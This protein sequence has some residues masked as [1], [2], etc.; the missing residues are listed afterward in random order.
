MIIYYDSSEQSWYHTRANEQFTFGADSEPLL[1][2]KTPTKNAIPFEVICRNNGNLGPLVG[3]L[4]SRNKNALITGNKPLFKLLQGELLDNGGISVVMTLEDLQ[5]NE[6]NGYVYLPYQKKWLKI[7]IPFPHIVYNRIPIRKIESSEI[8]RNTV[9]TFQEKGVKFFNPSFLNKYYLYELLKEDPRLNKY[10]PET[11]LVDAKDSLR[12]FLDRKQSLYL[13][14]TSSS[15][16]KGLFRIY[17]DENGFIS[18]QDLKKTIQFTNFNDF[19]NHHQALFRKK[20]YMAQKAITPLLYKGNRY[21]FRI[22]AHFDGKEYVVTGVGIRQSEKQ[23]VTTHLPH[24]GKLIAF[25]EVYRKKDEK[26]II[27]VVKHCGELLSKRLGFFGE[28]S[29]DAGITNEDDY[30]LYEVN[31]KPMSFDE[32]EIEKQRI[33][34]LVHLFK[35][36]FITM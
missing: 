24:G 28:F 21:D 34:H 31:S 35:Y 12:L 4:T 8:F 2:K 36:F 17:Q 22:L 13:K 11:I 26:F 27:E 32:E 18:S 20:E 9:N 10:V 7:A 16:G 14:P 3:I 19:W 33:G 25:E 23:S 5:R 30:V 1:Y 15:K 29:I 6:K